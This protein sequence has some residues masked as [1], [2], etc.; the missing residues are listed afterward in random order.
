MAISENRV[1]ISSITKSI[2]SIGEGLLSTGSS[3]PTTN[4]KNTAEVP[5]NLTDKL[6][7]LFNENMCNTPNY[8]LDMDSLFDSLNRGIN[9]GSLDVCGNRLTANPFDGSLINGFNSIKSNLLNSLT[10]LSKMPK[11]FLDG[12]NNGVTGV[13][14]KYKIPTDCVNGFSLSNP[15]NLNL[16]GLDLDLLKNGGK[17]CSNK[18]SSISNYTA[19]N[20][21]ASNRD[22]LYKYTSEM[23]EKDL[24]DTF[25]GFLSTRKDMNINNKVDAISNKLVVNSV[26]GGSNTLMV[27]SKV[28]E[29]LFTNPDDMLNVKVDSSN[30]ISNMDLVYK[31]K[32]Y[33]VVNGED[34]NNKVINSSNSNNTNGNNNGSNGNV[35]GSVNSNDL[36]Y[37]RD[38]NAI[39][40]SNNVI[41]GNNSLKGSNNSFKGY[42][43][44]VSIYD[45]NKEYSDGTSNRTMTLDELNIDLN[46]DRPHI[47]NYTSEHDRYFKVRHVFDMVD[48]TWNKDEDNNVSYHKLKKSNSFKMMTTAMVHTRQP[49]LELSTNI[50]PRELTDFESIYILSNI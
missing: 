23:T 3:T 31:D 28:K 34:K 45:M 32:I 33:E 29:D 36:E 40:Q 13:L 19:M 50:P 9:F 14:G 2:K 26:D 27:N 20:S 43:D 42:S 11:S 35:S 22:A 6:L 1:D 46:G 15:Y 48:K 12:I 24:M 38:V 44:G 30:I 39:N 7:G 41:I 17:L 4:A 25:G 16:S 49:M 21:I 8:K 37:G 5:Q 18:K 47:K 10:K